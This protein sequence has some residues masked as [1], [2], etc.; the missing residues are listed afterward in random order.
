MRLEGKDVS[1]YYEVRGSGTPLIMIHG[2]IVDA[3]LFS[4]AAEYLS[5]YFQVITYD[6]RGNSRSELKDKAG[7]DMNGQLEDILLLMD[8]LQIESAFIV[9]QSAGATIGQYFLQEYPEK[10]RH[11][12]MYE[13]A[14]F[15]FLDDMPNVHEWTGRMNELI[16]KRKFSSALLQFSQTIGPPDERRPKKTKEESLREMGNFE[17]GLSEEFPGIASYRPDIE[18]TRQYADRITLAMGEK[19]T[20]PVYMEGLGR[21]AEAIGTDILFYPGFHNLPFELPKEFAVNVLGTLMLTEEK[22]FHL[23]E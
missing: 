11:L 17:Y 9:G 4:R 3:N 5:R 16:R 13:P 15:G 1:L 22:A 23:S 10:V 21:F 7:N 18:K 6:R 19:T 20:D 2:V 14:I 12:I 8:T